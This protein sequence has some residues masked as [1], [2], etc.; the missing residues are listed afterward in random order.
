MLGF[1][2]NDNVEI[3]MARVK[4]TQPLLDSHKGASFSFGESEHAP[5]FLCC[6]L[7]SA[8]K[9]N[10]LIFTRF[11]FSFRARERLYSA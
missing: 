11:Q 3:T 10:F 6:L 2:L 8:T 1:T 5:D 4:F 9:I 7:T